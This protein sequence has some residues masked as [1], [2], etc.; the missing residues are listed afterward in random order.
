MSLIFRRGLSTIIPPK[1]ANPNAIGQ[2]QNA[3]RMARLV[4][5]YS[6]LPKGPAP[7]TEAKGLI[8][9]YK[10]KYFD[11]E[12]QS[13]A[14]AALFDAHPQCLWRNLVPTLSTPSLSSL[15]L[16]RDPLPK[17][18]S[19][20]AFQSLAHANLASRLC[21]GFTVTGIPI[22][23]AV[24]GE[25]ICAFVYPDP[26]Q[27]RNSGDFKISKIAACVMAEPLV[28]DV[29]PRLAQSVVDSTTGADGEPTLSNSHGVEVATV[30]S[31]EEANATKNQNPSTNGLADGSPV[32]DDS[33]DD[34]KDKRGDSPSGAS[35][36]ESI[37]DADKPPA[38]KVSAPRKPPAVK[39]VSLNKAFLSGNAAP[40]PPQ[41]GSGKLSLTL[42][43]GS[44]GTSSG[45]AGAFA[46]ASKPRLVSKIGPSGSRIGGIGQLGGKG[47][48]ISSVWNRNLPPTP[49][50]A[51]EYTDEEL[52]KHGIHMAERI[53]TEDSKEAKWADI[54]DE[55]DDW[56]PPDT[57]EWNDGTKVTLEASEIPKPTVSAFEKQIGTMA[58]KEQR[59]LHAA[60]TTGPTPGPMPLSKP[61][62]HHRLGKPEPIPSAL[63]PKTPWAAV[64]TGAFPTPRPMPP[65]M[66]HIGHMGHQGHQNHQYPRR[67]S[68][69]TSPRPNFLS[70]APPTKEVAADDFSRPSWRDRAPAQ[71]PNTLF[72][73]ETGNFDPVGDAHNREQGRRNSRAEG[74]AGARP[75]SLL[76]RTAGRG[77]AEH[78]PHFHQ[79]RFP[80]RPEPDQHHMPGPPPLDIGRRRSGSHLSAGMSDTSSTTRD[81]RHAQPHPPAPIENDSNVSTGGGEEAVDDQAPRA[82]QGPLYVSPTLA[83]GDPRFG[84]PAPPGAQPVNGGEVPQQEPGENPVEAQKR[85]MRDAREQA[86]A[87]RLAEEAAAE[88]EKRQRILK[89]LAELDERMKAEAASK[90][91]KDQ[92]SKP[93]DAAGNEGEAGVEAASS[94]QLAPAPGEAV[95]QDG[96]DDESSHGGDKDAAN[97]GEKSG[98]VVVSTPATGA[99][100]ATAVT[101]STSTTA[102]T[103]SH[104]ELGTEQP[105]IPSHAQPTISSPIHTRPPPSSSFPPPPTSSSASSSPT[106]TFS[107][108]THHHDSHNH[109]HSAALPSR[110]PDTYHPPGARSSASAPHHL[111]GPRPFDHNHQRTHLP[112]SAPGDSS[113]GLHRNHPPESSQDSIPPSQRG[114]HVHPPPPPHSYP[115]PPP[116]HLH[117]TAGRPDNANMPGPHVFP[118]RKIGEH[119]TISGIP[120]PP[121]KEHLY[122][123]DVSN[124]WKRNGVSRSSPWAP[125]AQETHVKRFAM[126]LPTPEKEKPVDNASSTNPNWNANGQSADTVEQKPEPTKAPSPRQPPMRASTA[127]EIAASIPNFT[128]LYNTTPDATIPDTCSTYRT[129]MAAVKAELSAAN[130]GK[131]L[132]QSDQAFNTIWAQR[133]ADQKLALEKAG[134][135]SVD[136]AY[137]L[138]AEPNSDEDAE[139]H[140]PA[141]VA[142]EG[143]MR[144]NRPAPAQGAHANDVARFDALQ[145]K[146]KDLAGGSWGNMTNMGNAN[147]YRP[148]REKDLKHV[149]PHLRDAEVAK[150]AQWRRDQRVTEAKEMADMYTKENMQ[151]VTDSGA[152]GNKAGASPLEVDPNLLVISK[153]T[154]QGADD[155][156]PKVSLPKAS[157]EA[158]P[159]I[160]TK[161]ELPNTLPTE[162]EFNAMAFQQEF[163]STP[164]VCLPTVI[165]KSF[166]DDNSN[167]QRNRPK[168]KRKNTL[169]D[170]DTTSK[171]QVPLQNFHGPQGQNVIRVNLP[172]MSAP[173]G[174][175]MS[176]SYQNTLKAQHQLQ[177]RNQKDH[178]SN[179][180][181]RGPRSDSGSKPRQNT[182]HHNNHPNNGHHNN[183]QQGNGPHNVHQNS[184]RQNNGHQNNGNHNGHQNG[185]NH[186]GHQNNYRRNNWGNRGPNQ[187]SNGIRP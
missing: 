124:E 109:S 71:S 160:S 40:A 110:Y 30:V 126:F 11:G 2:A 24:R 96:G 100:G 156:R 83:A 44:K 34:S 163:G 42:D 87:R 48:S 72:N 75:T 17:N 119:I 57:I 68:F 135:A 70:M 59:A 178:S 81:N 20:L 66:G 154:F 144:K 177:N 51:K 112:S 94:P 102:S 162:D 86:R 182:G 84:R 171:A 133:R 90:A 107:H 165:P 65:P 152:Q 115:H 26:L 46:T 175:I 158:K 103:Q 143:R 127:R 121:G 56:V 67:P 47:A 69:G 184:G 179:S 16:V 130:D 142:N 52:S 134:K 153:P 61:M 29:D 32:N 25:S 1:V 111:G 38:Q 166:T 118:P 141:P 117:S 54:D 60:H 76:Q 88:E 157:A 8:G 139:T 145:D 92:D 23:T 106:R 27:T 120:L 123:V 78:D 155:G 41:P 22:N 37:K 128:H 181:Q 172:G 180:F 113:N 80:G 101:P 15:V 151:A 183:G 3:V 7:K 116:S 164:T 136:V 167:N 173:Q 31:G 169:R 131:N 49:V 146:I 168:D 53:Q 4:D 82:S 174:F 98:D 108:P 73:S 50:P 105:E 114:N 6:K 185:G 58:L 132:M 33:K 104:H 74:Q 187:S 14:Q 176:Q 43:K 18:T 9:R 122:P 149:P 36:S 170:N 55:D 19:P 129:L 186:T 91:D 35:G 62:D 99:A 93:A 63:P 161:A 45:A 150:A 147:G 64:P 10:A 77:E 89:K 95:K 97:G 125:T 5:L 28:Q 39:S 85:V 159:P 148:A 79:N 137:N 12:N 13:G 138:E 140:E 21:P